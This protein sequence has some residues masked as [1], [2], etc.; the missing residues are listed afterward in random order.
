MYLP[1][2]R[3]DIPRVTRARIIWLEI[4]HALASLRDL[5]LIFPS[6]PSDP[7][8]AFGAGMTFAAVLLLLSATALALA[9]GMAVPHLILSLC[10]RK[11]SQ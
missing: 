4:V 3:T 2:T 10:F 7:V 5:R 1:S 11:A 8:T 9:V 6:V